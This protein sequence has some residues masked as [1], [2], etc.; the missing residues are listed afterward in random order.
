MKKTKGSKKDNQQS[1]EV[2]YTLGRGTLYIHY[3]IVE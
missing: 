2:T 1:A 3:I